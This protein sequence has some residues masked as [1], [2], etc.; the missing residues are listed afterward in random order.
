VDADA[1]DAVGADG[2][3]T[4]ADADHAGDTDDAGPDADLDAEADGETDSDAAGP[5][6]PEMALVEARGLRFCVDL[7]EASCDEVRPDGSIASWSPFETVDGVVVRARS[8][9]GVAPQGYISGDQADAACSLAG[10]ALCTTEQ[11]LLACRGPED[12]VW[13]YGSSQ[14]V[15]LCNDDYAGHPVVDYYGTT[16]DWIWSAEAMNDPGINQQPGTLALAGEHAECVSAF[17]AFEMVGN[18][19]E[20]VADAEGTFR[21]GFYVDVTLNGAGCTYATTAHGRGYHDYSTGFRC[22]SDASR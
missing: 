2:D 10:K 5:C 9:A 12:L 17:G 21:G 7:W 4:G 3:E 1:D 16:E 11:W 13:P 18:L 8:V 15:G 6:P 20:W 19:H 14:V 22:C